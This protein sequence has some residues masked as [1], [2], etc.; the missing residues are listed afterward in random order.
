[1]CFLLQ[2]LDSVRAGGP[3]HR[4]FGL[5]GELDKRRGELR[6]ITA[7]EAVHLLPSSYRLS[8]CVRVVR[9]GSLGPFRRLVCKQLSAEKTRFHDHRADAEW[10]DLG[11]QGLHPALEGELRG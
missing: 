8:C 4:R 3:A 6:W 10:R 11:R 5:A 7:L 2:R 1:M 9:D